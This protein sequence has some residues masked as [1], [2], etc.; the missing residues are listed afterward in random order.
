MNEKKVKY[1]I[2]LF[3]PI[4]PSMYV[5]NIARTIIHEKRTVCIQINDCLNFSILKDRN[6]Q[7]NK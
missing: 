4:L 7:E 2:Y 6:V 5:I 3:F 1:L